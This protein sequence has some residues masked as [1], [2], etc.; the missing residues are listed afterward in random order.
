MGL[1][2]GSLFGSW[3]ALGIHQQVV[4]VGAA[5][6]WAAAVLIFLVGVSTGDPKMM[7]SAVGPAAAASFMTAQA[8]MRRESAGVAM[9]GSS[10]IIAV[11]HTLIG[12]SGAGIPLSVALVVVTALAAM[13]VERHQGLAVGLPAAILLVLPQAWELDRLVAVQTGVVNA[14]A[15]VVAAVVFIAIRREVSK[16]SGRYRALFDDSPA[17]V[18]EEDWTEAVEYLRSEYDGRPERVERFLLAYP[19]VL[20]AAVGKAKVVRANPAAVHLLEVFFEEELVGYRDG[21]WVCDI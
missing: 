13:L 11:V 12:V 6:G 8:V 9:F 10:L 5:V 16:Y 15:F 21:I 4:R 18:L 7:L 14:V 3:S 17:A 2:S 1:M 20:R 19:P